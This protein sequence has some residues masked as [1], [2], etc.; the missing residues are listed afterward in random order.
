MRSFGAGFD[1][2][3]YYAGRGA[4]IANDR[5]ATQPFGRSGCQNE[6]LYVNEAD[7]TN[8]FGYSQTNRND[9]PPIC[10]APYNINS[11][12]DVSVDDAGNVILPEATGQIPIGRG[13]KMCGAQ[14][15]TIGNPFGAGVDA[16]S[17]DA[18]NG[19]IAV[20]TESILPTEAGGIAVCSV[21]NGCTT[22]LSQRRGVHATRRRD[23]SRRRIS[24][25]ESRYLQ[26]Q[27]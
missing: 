23:R 5:R 11:A 24:R 8:L 14:V 3:R 2:L 12:E 21:A 4:P 17:A 9:G 22:E 19:V 27:S 15:A 26:L 10:T 18:L 7:A 16:S 20:S 1:S 25:R 6:G 13:P